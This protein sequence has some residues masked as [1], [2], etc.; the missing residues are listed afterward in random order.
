MNLFTGISEGLA[1][2]LQFH[3]QCSISPIRPHVK[4]ADAD[5]QKPADSLNGSD[6]VRFHVG[7]TTG[8]RRK[9]AADDVRISLRANRLVFIRWIVFVRRSLLHLFQKSNAFFHQGQFIR[10]LCGFSNA[11][12]NRRNCSGSRLF[13]FGSRRYTAP[14]AEENARMLSSG[15]RSETRQSEPSNAS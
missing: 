8:Q 10:N 12:R 15:I 3:H 14:R 6:S 7:M 2:A 11:Q 1:F 5:Q 9:P 4:D 13:S